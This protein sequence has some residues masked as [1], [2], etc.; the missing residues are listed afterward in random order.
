MA[1]GDGWSSRLIAGLGQHLDDN[2]IGVWR[3]S[4]LY[5]ADEVGITDRAIPATP[6]Q[7][8][9]LALYPVTDVPGLADTTV[10]LQVRVRGTEDPRTAADLG[11][12]I[13]ELWHGATH[14]YLGEIRIVQIHRQSHAP[15]GADGNRRWEFAHNY[16]V[17]A[18]RPTTNN[19]D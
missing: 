5:T 19:T 3:D 17:D 7:I 12:A 2:G 13:Y 16:Y 4:G 14:L 1:V 9:T 8:I 18:M 15:L 10:G 11:D 6:D